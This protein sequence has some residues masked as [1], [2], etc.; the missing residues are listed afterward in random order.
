MKEDR[1]AQSHVPFARDLETAAKVTLEV[2]EREVFLGLPGSLQSGAS[3]SGTHTDT[4]TPSKKLWGWGA[5][6]PG[7]LV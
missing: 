7:V 3:E 6:A 1:C 2:N 5:Y 4:R